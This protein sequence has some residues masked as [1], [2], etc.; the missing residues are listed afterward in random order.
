[1]VRIFTPNAETE[2]Y[3]AILHW[4]AGQLN[5]NIPITTKNDQDE[6]WYILIE[7][8]KQLEKRLAKWYQEAT[9]EGTLTRMQMVGDL[10]VES[11]I[12]ADL[13]NK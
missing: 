8:D 12:R 2:H 11:W 5:K 6:Y 1:M 13:L 9:A 7:P 4:K 10:R 3:D